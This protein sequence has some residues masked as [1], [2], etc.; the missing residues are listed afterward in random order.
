MEV[1][2]KEMS[3]KIRKELPLNQHYD[4]LINVEGKIDKDTY[5]GIKKVI[6]EVTKYF[7]Q[8]AHN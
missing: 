2:P 1:S 8:E 4:N 5:P 3:E 7:T 6:Q